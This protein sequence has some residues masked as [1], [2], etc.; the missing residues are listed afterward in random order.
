MGHMRR[1]QER[2]SNKKT[3]FRIPRKGGQQRKDRALS[4]A[5]GITDKGEGVY[6]HSYERKSSAIGHPPYCSHEG[7]G[8]E[9]AKAT[10]A[11]KLGWAGFR[12][13]ARSSSKLNS[14]RAGGKHEH[15]K[16]NPLKIIRALAE[17]RQEKRSPPTIPKEGLVSPY[18][19]LWSRRRKRNVYVLYTTQIS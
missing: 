18:A 16:K 14:R 10:W 12:M 4:M 5:R 2:G 3:C 15:Y 19:K 8:Q 17:L 6:S 13:L 7:L 11:A 9:F 1:R